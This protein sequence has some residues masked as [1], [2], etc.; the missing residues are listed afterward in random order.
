MVFLAEMELTVPSVSFQ[1]QAFAHRA[2]F[3][4]PWE[5]AC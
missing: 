1:Q 2:V 3:A 4:T 5:A